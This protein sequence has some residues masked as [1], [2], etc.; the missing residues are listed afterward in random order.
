MEKIGKFDLFKATMNYQVISILQV[1]RS[2]TMGG[3]KTVPSKL[4]IA[5]ACIYP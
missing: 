1:E 3:Q 4:T 2:L 5:N